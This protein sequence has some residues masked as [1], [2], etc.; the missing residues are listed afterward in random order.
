MISTAFDNTPPRLQKKVLSDD[1]VELLIDAI[2]KGD[3]PP[4]SKIVELQAAK[5]FSV[6]QSTI[7]EALRELEIRGFL[8]SKPYKGTFVRKFTIEGLKDYFKTRTELEILAA[9]WAAE[10]KYWNMNNSRMERLLHEMGRFVSEEN[11]VAFRKKDME[12][13]K[14]LV[15]SSGSNSLLL[16]WNAL[17]HSYWAYFGLFFEKQQYNLE[18]QMEKH[19]SIYGILKAGRQE[20]LKKAIESHYVDISYILRVLD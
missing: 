5:L 4:G 16:A 15:E 17:S 9:G 19:L 11:H 6:S 18:D 3:F 10:N 13:H 1:I 20:E 12:F 14:T 7:R 2:M 8:E